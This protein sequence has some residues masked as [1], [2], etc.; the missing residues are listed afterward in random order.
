MSDP[1]TFPRDRLAGNDE[2][3]ASGDEIRRHVV[4]ARRC[5]ERAY[6]LRIGSNGR[7]KKEQE[8]R[9]HLEQAFAKGER[10]G[11]SVAEVTALGGLAVVDDPAG[12]PLVTD[13]A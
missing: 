11:L 9:Y 12:R 2:P 13:G 7:I 10:R 8:A 5:A 1:L 3:K 6:R 4:R